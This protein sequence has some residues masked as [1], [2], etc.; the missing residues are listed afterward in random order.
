[1]CVYI[2]FS[3]RRKIPRILLILWLLHSGSAHYRLVSRA[4]LLLLLLLL[5]LLP[6]SMT[7]YIFSEKD[8]LKGPK[9]TQ[10][11]EIKLGKRF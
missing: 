2:P 6:L 9:Q 10:M 3:Q 7:T 4:F 5:L 11:L 1:M 8:S